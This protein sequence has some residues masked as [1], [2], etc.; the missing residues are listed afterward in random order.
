M[1]AQDILALFW[2]IDDFCKLF[3]PAWH[4]RQLTCG[5]RK[6]R[7]ATRLT[8]SELMTLGVHFHHSHYRNFKAYSLLSVCGPLRDRFPDLLSYTR[9]VALIPFGP[10]GVGLPPK[11]H[12]HGHRVD[13]YRRSLHRGMPQSPYPPPSGVQ[14]DRQTW[15]DFHR[16]VLWV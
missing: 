7:R 13:L 12:R 16:P 8:A 15:Q 14:E 9:F 6:R 5:E 2:D 1:N 3:I 10:P 11:P 4:R